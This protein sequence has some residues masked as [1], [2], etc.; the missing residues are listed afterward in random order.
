MRTSVASPAS[1]WTMSARATSNDR[2]S[3]ASGEQALDHDRRHGVA[4]EREHDDRREREPGEEE[5]GREEDERSR[6]RSATHPRRCR[7]AA[8]RRERSGAGVGGAEERG[9]DEEHD[10]ASGDLQPERGLV[11]DRDDEAERQREEEVVAVELQRLRHEL[12]RR[13]ASRATA[14]AAAGRSISGSGGAP[15]TRR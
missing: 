14:A 12:A 9:R 2:L 1:A 5:R 10:D 3:A 11:G 15:S 4:E 8:L 13:C 6:R 7:G